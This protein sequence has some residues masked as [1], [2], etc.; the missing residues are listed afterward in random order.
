[1]AAAQDTNW[2]W[3]ARREILAETIKRYAPTLPRADMRVAEVGCGTGGNLP[4]LAQFGEVLGAEHE[5]EAL[6]QLRQQYGDTYRVMQHSVPAPLP[7]P[8]SILGMFDVLEHIEDDAGAM[9]WV[10][11]QLAPGGIAVITVPAFPFLWSE[12]DEAVHHFRRYTTDALLR[13]V[14]PSLEILHTTYFNSLLFAPIAAVRVAM[15]LLPKRPAGQAQTHGTQTPEPFNS[16]FYQLFRLERHLV[17]AH[18][19]PV[20]VSVLCVLRRPS[21]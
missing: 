12:H 2:W 1:M 14:P 10:S 15:K 11:R 9:E 4:M 16:L 21:D 19:C 3:R 13:L 20:G 18:R 7:G 8:F 17:P 6:V 5:P